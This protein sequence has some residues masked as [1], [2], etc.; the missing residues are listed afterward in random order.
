MKCRWCCGD[1]QDQPLL[2]LQGIPC[3]AQSFP[4]REELENDCGVDLMIH[5]CTEC[6]LVQTTGQTVPYHRE[7]LRAN[8]YSPAMKM[9]RQQ[10]LSEWVLRHQLT[11]QPVLEVGCGR[12][13]FLDLL[14]DAGAMVMGTEHGQAAAQVAREQGHRVW[15]VYP[16]DGPLPPHEGFSGWTSFNFMEHWP[17]PKAVLRSVRQRLRPGAVGLVEVPNFEMMLQ[18][19]LLT[20]FIPDH[21]AYFTETTLQRC[22]EGAGFD[23]D[24]IRPIWHGY[25]LSAE[26]RLRTP[27]SLTGFEDQLKSLSHQLQSFAQQHGEGRLAVWGAGHQSLTTLAL[28]DIHRKVRYVV[29][30]APFKQGRYTP[31]THLPI[32]APEALRH[33]PVDAVIVMAAGYADEVLRTIRQEFDPA[34]AVAVVRESGLEIA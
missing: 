22:L 21:V 25:I 27:A 6:N 20:E 11:G 34:L 15:Q 19:R 16:G 28:A 1:L 33:D 4:L 8:A 30:S 3:G 14:R 18:Q 13:E 12:G 9:F 29:D 32:R 10:Q 26:I 7:V 23:V 2:T 31:A 24:R 5:R 17:D